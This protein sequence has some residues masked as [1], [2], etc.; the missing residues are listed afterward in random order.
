MPNR[1]KDG[2]ANQVLDILDKV[3]SSFNGFEVEHPA[4]KNHE[5]L[6][7]CLAGVQLGHVG[8][9]NLEFEEVHVVAGGVDENGTMEF[10]NCESQGW[11]E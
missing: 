2:L 5:G 6:I 3:A 1:L 8:T 10:S 11:S 4:N 7:G 9:G